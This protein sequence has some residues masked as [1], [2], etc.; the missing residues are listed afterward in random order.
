M[1]TSKPI[2]VVDDDPF[3]LEFLKVVLEASEYPVV[4]ASD[5]REALAAIESAEASLILLDMAMPVLDGFGFLAEMRRKPSCRAPVVVMTAMDDARRLA[6]DLGVEGW[7]Q[8]PFDLDTLLDL[9][10]QLAR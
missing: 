3:I 6:R 7:L 8:K 5:G 1:R 9:V 4:T 10:A 2:L